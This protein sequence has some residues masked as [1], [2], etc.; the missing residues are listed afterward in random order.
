ME[1]IV[2]RLGSYFEDRNE[3]SFALLFGSR[4]SGRAGED[5][6]VDI[7]VYFRL[8][9]NELELESPDSRYPSEDAL[10]SD[11]ERT[12][13]ERVDLVVLNRV[14]A[15]VAAAALI[16]GVLVCCRDERL[17]RRF[18]LAATLLAEDER[19]FAESYLGIK[20]RSRSISE[21]DRLGSTTRPTDL[22]RGPASPFRD[23]GVRPRRP[24]RAG[25]FLEV[26][27]SPRPRVPRTPLSVYRR[28]RPS[29]STPFPPT[30]R[31]GEP[32][33][34]AYGARQMIYRFDTA[35]GG[36]G[37]TNSALSRPSPSPVAAPR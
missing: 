13:G 32:Y 35:N 20:A 1:G 12:L 3:I 36:A 24:R 28:F 14:A 2:D 11:I 27:E 23:L 21:I 34:R 33:S 7:A 25:R 17:Y 22:Q 4:A 31:H 19:R 8:S 18:L 10:W 29:H 6:D 16:E 37:I 30:R 9:G 15:T 26:E 5:S